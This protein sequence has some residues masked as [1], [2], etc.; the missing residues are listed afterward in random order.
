[1]KDRQEEKYQEFY[2]FFTSAVSQK[3]K[4]DVYNYFHEDLYGNIH[5]KIAFLMPSV[6]RSAIFEG[7]LMCLTTAVRALKVCLFKPASAQHRTG[8]NDLKTMVWTKKINEN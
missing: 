5:L 2:K 8:E 4:K 7:V 6:Q 3:G 1:M